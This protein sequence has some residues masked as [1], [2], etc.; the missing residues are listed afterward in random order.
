MPKVLINLIGYVKIWNVEKKGEDPTALIKS[1][2]G[3]K[4]RI[5]ALLIIKH[6]VITG[7]NDTKINV[8]NEKNDCD[9]C[10]FEGHKGPVNS[11]VFKAELQFA[12]L[13]YLK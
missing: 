5:N 1:Y 10:K 9:D 3:H 8:F 6:Y 11:L 2:R 7:G 12:S 4:S 13:I